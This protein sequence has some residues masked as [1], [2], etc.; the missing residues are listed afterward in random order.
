MVNTNMRQFQASSSVLLPKLISMPLSKQLFEIIAQNCH[1]LMLTVKC[2][3]DVDVCKFNSRIHNR[4]QI[5]GKTHGTLPSHYMALMKS[6][7]QI[8]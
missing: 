4:F 3:I 6:A 2:A 8:V 7:R 1:T 5:S